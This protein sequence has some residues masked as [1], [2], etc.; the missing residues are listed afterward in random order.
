VNHCRA[1]VRQWFARRADDHSEGFALGGW[2][3]EFGG[4]DLEAR[5]STR[6]VGDGLALL[7]YELM[8]AA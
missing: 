7:T 2:F 8:R 3:G 5:A 4:K 1:A 6:T